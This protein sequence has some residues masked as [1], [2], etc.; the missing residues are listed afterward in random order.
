MLRHVTCKAHRRCCSSLTSTLAIVEQRAINA[1]RSP[2][3]ESEN[4]L[5]EPA[6]T[7]RG[8]THMELAVHADDQFLHAPDV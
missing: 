6:C 3:L 4:R 1:R 2:A 5:R 8:E 7:R